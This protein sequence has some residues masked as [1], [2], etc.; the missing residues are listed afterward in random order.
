MRVVLLYPLGTSCLVARIREI[1]VSV[2]PY[3]RCHFPFSVFPLDYTTYQ[4]HAIGYQGT[5]AKR[6]RYANILR[7]LGG[8]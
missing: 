8:D 1:I 4:T 6:W 3:K 2:F 5:S 7:T